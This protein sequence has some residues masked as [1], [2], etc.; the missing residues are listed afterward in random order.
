LKQLRAMVPMVLACAGCFD[1]PFDRPMPDFKLPSPADMAV[2]PPD[3]WCPPG[4]RQCA[5]GCGT[6]SLQ[7][8]CG[9]KLCGSSCVDLARD[10]NNCGACGN[11]CPPGRPCGD[12][13]IGNQIQCG[14]PGRL[15][16][17]PNE[18]GPP[19]CVDP[20][21]DPHNCGTCG[22]QCK[23]CNQFGCCLLRM[24]W[25]MCADQRCVDGLH[26]RNNCG[27]CDVKC[28]PGAGCCNGFC[29]TGFSDAACPCG[30][31]VTG[32]HCISAGY[33]GC[34]P[35]EVICGNNNSHCLALASDPA[36]C[37]ACGNACAQGSVCSN[38]ACKQVCDQGLTAC[39]AECVNLN[40]SHQHCGDC[41][42]AC[43]GGT[44]CV[45]GQCSCSFGRPVCN[46]LCTD[47]MTDRANCGGC[48]KACV[49]NAKCVGGGCQCLPGFTLCNGACSSLNEDANCG[50]CGTAC[51]N[52]THCV[53][54]YCV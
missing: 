17:C 36:N 50:A 20:W 24:D 42:N 48:G 18:N 33:C 22:M 51:P 27:S 23:G 32:F 34:L 46:G 53:S 54:G 41:A 43:Q 3:L 39:G 28:A 21:S 12:G 7:D 29:D 16:L 8:C 35:G 14:C 15:L 44:T 5:N 49:A 31:C 37:G 1:S 52:G 6:P 25:T 4:Q 40:A 45:N 13:V 2:A 47:T 11:V 10:Q 26:D 19:T 9:L 30:P 38:G